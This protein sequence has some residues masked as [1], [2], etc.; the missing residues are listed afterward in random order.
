MNRSK[1]LARLMKDHTYHSVQATMPYH[2]LNF[3]YSEL[4]TEREM[5]IVTRSGLKAEYDTELRYR[6]GVNL[7]P[8]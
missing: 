2:L 5:R 4:I 6:I 3:D 7:Q 1:L 8:L